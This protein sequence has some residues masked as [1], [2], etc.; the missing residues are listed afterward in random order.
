MSI[1]I[2]MAIALPSVSQNAPEAEP[3][4]LAQKRQGIL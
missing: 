2:S 4:Q 1:G 3:I